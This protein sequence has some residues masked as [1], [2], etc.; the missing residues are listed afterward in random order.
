MQ[1]KKRN[2]KQRE[3]RVHNRARRETRGSA[4]AVSRCVAAGSLLLLLL[5][6]L[7]LRCCL[8]TALRRWLPLSTALL[9]SLFVAS[10]H[11]CAT[12]QKKQSLGS[13]T[14]ALNCPHLG[15]AVDW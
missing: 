2:N 10:M 6:S 4:A 1:Q 15:D 13:S 7:Q 9:A 8:F 14:S 3:R 12:D 5:L 11:H